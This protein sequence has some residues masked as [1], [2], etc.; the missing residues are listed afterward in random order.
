MKILHIDDNNIVRTALRDL[1]QMEWPEAVIYGAD[2]GRSG[3]NQAMKHQPDLILLDGQM[4]LMN[5]DETAVHL[6]TQPE[7]QHIPII[8]LTAEVPGTSI[9]IGLRQYCNH[10]LSKSFDIDTFLQLIHQEI[11]QTDYLGNA[12]S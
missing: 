1:L 9:W 12:R 7:T 2:N 6:R 11:Q 10:I 4:P 5:G 3:L 8:A